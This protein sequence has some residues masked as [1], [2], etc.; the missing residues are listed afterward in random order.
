MR[1]NIKLNDK[2]VASFDADGHNK[3]PMGVLIRMFVR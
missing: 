3:A 2:V 1:Q